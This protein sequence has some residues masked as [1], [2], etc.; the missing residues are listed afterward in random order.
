ME[1][2]LN[3][4]DGFNKNEI[5]KQL[6][7]Q[8]EPLLRGVHMT[9]V[10]KDVYSNHLLI[11]FTNNTDKIQFKKHIFL[12]FLLNEITKL[13]YHITFILYRIFTCYMDN[14]RTESPF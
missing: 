12:L 8:T 3:H 10:S 9:M 7:V 6:C 13:M 4:Q 2:Y 5:L 14:L 11:G 1:L